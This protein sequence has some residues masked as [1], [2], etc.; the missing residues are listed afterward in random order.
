MHLA[1]PLAF[2][3]CGQLPP[4]SVA[5]APCRPSATPCAHSGEPGLV[6]N[7]PRCCPARPRAGNRSQSPSRPRPRRSMRADSRPLDP[8]PAHPTVLLPLLT[9]GQPSPR[10]VENAPEATSTA[11]AGADRTPQ[12]ASSSPG[13]PHP[14]DRHLRRGHSTW[15]G[16][17][18]SGQGH[19][20]PSG[21]AIPSPNA[22]PVPGRTEMS[23]HAQDVPSRDA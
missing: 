11:P 1:G 23:P 20:T 6:E 9:R 8:S 7:A 3:L 16:A 21:T 17:C 4:G 10:V 19:S 13:H 14:A 12:A 18:P 22:S 15:P 5:G 2:R